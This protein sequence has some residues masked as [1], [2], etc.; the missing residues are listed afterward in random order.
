MNFPGLKVNTALGTEHLNFTSIHTVNGDVKVKRFKFRS[1]YSTHLAYP[2][3]HTSSAWYTSRNR[4]R[5][6]WRTGCDG[7]SSIIFFPS[8]ALKFSP[9]PWS[10]FVC[11]YII[12]ILFSFILWG[13]S[14][15]QASKTFVT[16]LP[17]SL[18][19]IK[20]CHLD[21]SV[22]TQTFKTLYR[23]LIDICLLEKLI[24]TKYPQPHYILRT[25]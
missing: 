21:I 2:R 14:E 19:H 4:R 17:D 15:R 23:Y 22:Y 8:S 13:S 20:I 11:L 5:T 25:L 18:V 12:Y 1:F 3:G 6:R 16:P 9:P 7:H 24:S 10:S